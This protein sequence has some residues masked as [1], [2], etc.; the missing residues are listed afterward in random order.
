[1]N[2]TTLTTSGGACCHCHPPPSPCHFTAATVVEGMT[3]SFTP[4]VVH[5]YIH[6]IPHCCQTQATPSMPDQ[7][8]SWKQELETSEQLASQQP[9]SHPPPACSGQTTWGQHHCFTAQW[10]KQ[11]SGC[12]LSPIVPTAPTGWQLLR[13]SHQCLYQHHCQQLQDQ[14]C[15]HTIS[16]STSA[17][18]PSQLQSESTFS[19]IHPPSQAENSSDHV[20]P[21][22]NNKSAT[23]LPAE[24]SSDSATTHPPATLTISESASSQAVNVAAE[25]E[26]QTQE[27]KSRREKDI[28]I[29]RISYVL[30]RNLEAYE[31]VRR[32]FLLPSGEP[33]LKV[34]KDKDVATGEEEQIAMMECN[35]NDDGGQEGDG[36]DEELITKKRNDFILELGIKEPLDASAQKIVSTYFTTYLLSLSDNARNR[37]FDM[38]GVRRNMAEKIMLLVKNQKRVPETWIW[39]CRKW[40]QEMNEAI[41]HHK[42]TDSLWNER[43]LVLEERL[44]KSWKENVEGARRDLQSLTK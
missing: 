21:T 10:V 24:S 44:V 8:I 17:A 20:Q 11:P 4:A 6:Y 36:E 14:T 2:S 18:P 1:M 31:S 34:S 41:R 26:K 23:I 29:A 19:V 33:I 15:Q 13:P 38:R 42:K 30:A 12:Q 25:V 16:V 37:R 22:V 35:L 9:P 7:P 40:N 5:H 43:M 39:S 27:E 32:R 3:H 28:L